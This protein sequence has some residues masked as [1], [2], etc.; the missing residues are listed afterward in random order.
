MSKLYGKYR[1][2]ILNSQLGEVDAELQDK[3][4]S[5]SGCN[6]FSMPV[7]LSNG[8]FKITGPV[9]ST[10]RY[11]SNDNDSKY[12]EV[13]KTVDG[14]VVEGNILYLTVKGVRVISLTIRSSSSTSTTSSNIYS[15]IN[16]VIQGNYNLTFLNTNLRNVAARIDDK[17][18]VFSGCN[19][20]TI[21]CSATVG[22]FKVLG[23]D[24]ASSRKYCDL[25]NDHKYIDILKSANSYSL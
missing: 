15:F 21:P 20:F 13:L 5:F 8:V 4:I 17:N 9:S 25:D 10:L 22:L 24:F 6:V 23:N 16:K 1:L 2:R 19:T 7:S 3:I 12:K 14:Y 11:C 18:I